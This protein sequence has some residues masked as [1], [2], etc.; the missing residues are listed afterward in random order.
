M[1]KAIDFAKW[2]A[3]EKEFILEG[4]LSMGDVSFLKGE[5]E[6]GKSLFK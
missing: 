3:P 5:Y 6:V 4:W 2:C 1:R